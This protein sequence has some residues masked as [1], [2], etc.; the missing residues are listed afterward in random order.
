MLI[1]NDYS[2]TIMY[3]MLPNMDIIGTEKT[4]NDIDAAINYEFRVSVKEK[5]DTA[6]P[7]TG[8][9]KVLVTINDVI[10]K[11][12]NQSTLTAHYGQAMRRARILFM[13]ISGSRG[14]CSMK[15]CAPYRNGF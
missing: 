7:T 5:S 4:V 15:S 1:N 11:N 2:K 12:A 10:V 13:R 3:M 6:T 9:G 8:F 14:E